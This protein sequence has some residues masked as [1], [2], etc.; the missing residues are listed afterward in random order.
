IFDMCDKILKDPKYDNDIISEPLT[1]NQKQFIGQLESQLS[2]HLENV[3][4]YTISFE[5]SKKPFLN[6]K[7][8]EMKGLE[9][10]V[11]LIIAA[12][13][14]PNIEMTIVDIC[15]HTYFKDFIRTYY[16]LDFDNTGGILYNQ[17]KTIILA[18]KI[19]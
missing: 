12:Q 10:P 11:A 14:Y 1:V 9:Y 18:T 3:G 19:K 8:E 5:S 16:D 6:M 15:N 17:L 2:M 13:G 7:I 4:A